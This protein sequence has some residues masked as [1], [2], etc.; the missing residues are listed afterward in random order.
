[1]NDNGIEMT[2]A[3]DLIN[4]GTKIGNLENFLSKFD[5]KAEE[6]SIEE[7][8]SISKFYSSTR[9]LTYSD[10][11]LFK[12]RIV[13]LLFLEEMLEDTDDLSTTTDDELRQWIADKFENDVKFRRS[14]Q[15]ILYVENI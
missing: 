4:L 5:R 13:A 10:L 1:M 15:K 12:H 6:L 8:Y 3:W 7:I 2:K 14:A 9:G 11:L